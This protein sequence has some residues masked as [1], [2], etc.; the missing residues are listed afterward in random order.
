MLKNNKGFTLVELLAVIVILAIIVGITLVTI[1]PTIS[2]S[3]LKSFRTTLGVIERWL[4]QQSE[5]LALSG[6]YT[7]NEVS[8]EFIDI[9]G[10]TGSLCYYKKDD[11]TK[12]G[13]ILNMMDEDIDNK[14]KS[15]KF[16][17]AA[18]LKPENYT[19]FL[20]A[21]DEPS[22][23]VCIKATMSTNG[24]FFFADAISK[25]ENYY[26]STACGLELFA[27]LPSITTS[28]EYQ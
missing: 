20:I 22:A 25:N 23:R 11:L 24:E 7:I 15:R 10:P 16:I 6:G 14:E 28:S 1:L 17:T 2:N 5:L 19:S 8:K 27:N 13:K 26:E 21:I 12:V 18:G 3:K 4:T 9:C